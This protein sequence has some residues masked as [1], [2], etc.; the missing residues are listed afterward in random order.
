MTLPRRQNLTN[1]LAADTLSGYGKKAD[2]PLPAPPPV[3]ANATN[4]P[5][6]AATPNPAF[7]KLKGKWLHPDVVFVRVPEGGFAP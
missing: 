5:A 4:Q 3:A 6:P 1:L 2:A 7:E